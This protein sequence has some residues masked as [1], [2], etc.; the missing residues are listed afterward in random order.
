MGSGAA[1][2][3]RGRLPGAGD[4]ESRRL[5]LQCLQTRLPPGSDP[6]AL[7]YREEAMM[8]E[9][10]ACH[11]RWSQESR[12]VRRLGPEAPS[13]LFVQGEPR[14]RGP[15]VA[16]VGTRR[17]DLYGLV[18]ARTLARVLSGAGV[19]VVSG[20]ALGVDAEAHRGAL[21]GP[22]GTTVVL[23]GGLTRPHPPS[24][25]SLFR[26]VLWHRAGALVSEAPMLAPPMPSSFPRRNRL[27]AAMADAVVVV[28]AGVPSGALQTAQW[29]RRLGVDVYA[30][31]GDVW[32][33]RSE[34]CHA[35]LRDG[36][37]PLTTPGD[38]AQ[39]PGLQG[40]RRLRWPGGGR[41]PSLL[42]PTWGDTGPGEP[43]PEVPVEH[44]KV[45]EA[46]EEGSQDPD[47]LGAR[48]G[49]SPSLL[50]SALSMLEVQGRVARLPGGL[51]VRT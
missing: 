19:R 4:P 3:P 46:L 10:G 51:W 49:L 9:L 2:S 32:Y 40:L 16:V 34:G 27:I 18:V 23:A 12:E 36:A 13:L 14:S 42:P 20:G 37:R 35:L 39:T 33:E 31:P 43:L 48:T 28:Q 15:T 17:P 30:V 44:R 38:L 50:L 21:E 25:R 11:W 8:E 41:R 1:A 6:G 47:A 7:L 5:H 26:E 29:A 45:L 24:N 22:G